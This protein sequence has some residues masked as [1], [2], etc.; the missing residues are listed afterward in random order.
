MSAMTRFATGL[1]VVCAALELHAQSTRASP[2]ASTEQL[3]HQIESCLPPPVVVNGEP[4]ACTPLLTRMQQ[5]HVHGV[6]IAVVHHGVIEWARGYGVATP[7]GAQV[8]AE[9]LFQAGSISKPVAA[10][11]ALHLVQEGKLSLDADVNTILTSWKVPPSD[12]APGA[13]I[14]LRELLTH[15]GGTTV[16]GF[17]GYAAG[18]PVPTVVQVLNGEKPANTPAIRIE[19]VPGKRWNYSGG[20]YTIMQQMM[21]DV[22]HEPFPKLLHDT[23]LAP[24]GMTHSTYE[25]P[26]PVAL[27]AHAAAPYTA[28]GEPVEGGAHTYPEMAAAGLWT[29][30]SDLSRYIIENQRSLK[31]EAITCSRRR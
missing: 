9:T 12:A 2:S 13:V 30:P 23:V 20:G 14:T 19:A 25:Q 31:G 27:Q 11:A 24:I 26:L 1:L 16:H 22:A 29:T 18:T 5:L 28:K 15:T 17:P 7:S 6:S 8:T 4:P 3:I 10:M 21:L